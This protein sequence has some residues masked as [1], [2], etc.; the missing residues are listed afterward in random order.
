MEG[1]GTFI[2]E[3]ECCWSAALCGM[4]TAEEADFMAQLLGSCAVPSELNDMSHPFGNPYSSF[5]SMD[6]DYNLHNFLPQG[7]GG[8][9]SVDSFGF[10]TPTFKSYGITDADQFYATNNASVS[11]DFCMVD[12]DQTNNP[13]P[14]SLMEEHTVCIIN[15]ENGTSNLGESGGIKE[16]G[17]TV[18]DQKLQQPKRKFEI[19]RRPDPITKEPKRRCRVPRN[20][21]N[22][23]SKKKAI[24]DTDDEEANAG[25]N[26][27]SS[28]SC[29]SEDDS[30][31]SLELNGIET[32]YSKGSA[33]LNSSGKS[34]ASR[35]SATDPQSLYARKR[36]ERINER[37]R[38][39]QC[40]VPNGTKVDISTMLEEAAQYVK[41]LQLQI[42]LLSSDDMWMYAPIAYNGMDIGLD[43][44]GR[45]FTDLISKAN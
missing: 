11:T 5:P 42:K 20:K 39:L 8:I 24:K 31:A 32:S 33:S 19:P 37:L 10:P 28:S 35:G 14:D 9:S 26:G 43:L 6:E 44:K 15:Q 23:D 7:G 40:L 3:G 12:D 36:R 1:V 18:L 17:V 45:P 16:E 13:F 38:I 41:F 25:L 22:A 4:S 27:Q 29:S 21:K 34:R 30:N 2:T